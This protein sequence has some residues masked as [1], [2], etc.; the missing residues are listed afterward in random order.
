MKRISFL[1]FIFGVIFTLTCSY[2]S[3]QKQFKK[4]EAKFVYLSSISFAKGIND[5][6]FASRIVP[7]KTALISVNQVIAYKFNPFIY[8]GIG[9]GYD[10]WQKTGFIPLYAS[11]NINFK[12][13]EWTPFFYL[14]AGYSFKW[15]VTQKPEYMTRVIH[16]Y[17]PGV[18]GESGL[19]LQMK[20]NDKF[21]LLLSV[22]YKLQQS[23]IAYSVVD[24]DQPDLS[25]IS[26]N[27]SAFALYHFL[28]FRLGFIF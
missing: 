16:G 20:M 25:Q 27:R 12:R 18:Y 14:N 26:T 19:G 23:E 11:L 4:E 15:Y 21:A 5:I 9:A 24:P 7:N 3:A 2:L 28:G 6:E 22:N 13:G 17:K 8:T 1:P 10:M